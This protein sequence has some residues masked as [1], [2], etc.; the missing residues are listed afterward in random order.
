[1]Q[2]TVCRRVPQTRKASGEGR[3]AMKAEGERL[4]RSYISFT[5]TA[6]RTAAPHAQNRNRW[7]AWKAAGMFCEGKESQRRR[8]SRQAEGEQ[9]QPRW[10]VQQPRRRG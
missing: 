1:M 4:S 6:R 5:A 10:Q 7:R 8:Q 2:M 9:A 3:A